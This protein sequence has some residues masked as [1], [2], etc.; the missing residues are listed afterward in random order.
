VA[1]L[2]VREPINRLLVGV[3]AA[4]L[5]GCFVDRYE[6]LDESPRVVAASGG[7]SGA[8]GNG[9][10]GGDYAVHS[11]AGA[12]ATESGGLG[13]DSSLTGGAGGGLQAGGRTSSGGSG[14]RTGGAAGFAGMAGS[15]GSPVPC[16]DASPPLDDPL[17]CGQ[18]GLECD[19]GEHCRSGHCCPVG[20]DWCSTEG[21][22]AC[23]DVTYD[24]EHCGSCGGTCLVSGKECCLGECVYVAT[25][26]HDPMNC[27]ACGNICPEPADYSDACLFWGD[28]RDPSCGDDGSGVTICN[29][30]DFG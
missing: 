14:G 19:P 25:Y 18:C 16:N 8:R 21:G 20:T 4:S 3:A 12:G 30:G 6:K 11:G 17:N 9:A 28:C 24:P 5:F 10:V 15:A 23:I 13:G 7:S 29:P 2:V 26:K 1:R 22:E 27:G